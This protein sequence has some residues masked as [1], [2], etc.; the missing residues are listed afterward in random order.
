MKSYTINHILPWSEIALLSSSKK[1][2]VHWGFGSR[3]IHKQSSNSRA[4]KLERI[5]DTIVI[6]NVLC[7]ERDDIST[8]SPVTH[9]VPYNGNVVYSQLLCIHSYL[10]NSLGCVSVQEDS[11][12]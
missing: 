11:G 5:I 12:S 6:S 7:L 10:S 2:R 9:L 3:I 4:I 1:Q 8:A